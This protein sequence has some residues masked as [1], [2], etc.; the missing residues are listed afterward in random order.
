MLC[1]T[2]GLQEVSMNV[3][4]VPMFALSRMGGPWS[5]AQAIAAA[6]DRA[7]HRVVLAMADDGN[8]VGPCVSDTCRLPVPAPLGLPM[9]VSSRTFPVAE[10]L[11]I[12][13]RKPVH[14][15]EEVL[16]LTGALDYAYELESVDAIR[17]AV[18]L[19]AIDVIYSEFS[20]PAIIAGRA[21]G[22]PVFGSF[23][24]TTQ[25]SYA[26]NPGKASGVRKLLRD[27]GLNDVESSLD[28]FGWLDRRF[29]PSCR[30]LEPIEDDGIEFV[31]FLRDLPEL[32]SERRSEQR[33]ERRSEQ[34]DCVLVYLGAGSVPQR[35]VEKVVVSA[36]GSFGEAV[37]VAGSADERQEGDVYFA[38]RFDFSQLLPR[39]R[40]FVHHGGQNSTMDALA[41]GVPQVI[42]PGRVFER[43][44]NAESIERVGAGVKLEAL[45]PDVLAD[46]CRRVVE[47]P[48]FRESSMSMRRLLAAG[49]GAARIVAV[50]E[51]AVG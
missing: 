16:W 23:S 31:G 38:P 1:S 8:C 41:Y 32:G 39:A 42:V 10:R 33:D 34:R 49:G 6:F 2:T 17:A 25:A 35:R 21:L 26:S 28:L 51:S 30:E 11:G 45:E 22:L 24:F 40:C 50:V 19:H 7:G 36:L 4:V 9:A 13:G 43:R 18:E 46:A 27:I 5:R 29:V 15:F 14:S 37:Y 12:A 20:L 3:L 48:E 47:D 44:Y